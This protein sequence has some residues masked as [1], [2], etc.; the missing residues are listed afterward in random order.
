[1]K[2]FQSIE[3]KKFDSN[4][5]ITN[6]CDLLVI[7][8]YRRDSNDYYWSLISNPQLPTIAEFE[9]VHEYCSNDISDTPLSIIKFIE[10]KGRLQVYSPDFVLQSILKASHPKL[11]QV[12]L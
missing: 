8:V 5:F 9:L 12:S 6:K 1:M 2:L 7:S 3:N 11:I 10:H 4:A